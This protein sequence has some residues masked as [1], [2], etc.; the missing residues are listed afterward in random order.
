MPRPHSLL[1]CR[2]LACAAVFCTPLL[3]QS[4]HVPPRTISNEKD[5]SLRDAALME[6]LLLLAQGSRLA[7]LDLH[8]GQRIPDWEFEYGAPLVAVEYDPQQFL[9]VT[10]TENRLCVYNLLESLTPRI[11]NLPPGEKVLTDVKLLPGQPSVP[12]SARVALLSLDKLRTIQAVNGQLVQTSARSAP[13]DPAGQPALSA[14]LRLCVHASPGGALHALVCGNLAQYPARG[15]EGLASYAILDTGGNGPQVQPASWL[16]D[17][18]AAFG[19][20]AGGDP[21]CKSSAHQV[22]C[23][24][25]GGLEHLYVACGSESPGPGRARALLLHLSTGD[26]DQ[27][28]ALAQRLDFPAALPDHEVPCA[29]NLVADAARTK[30][31]VATS[32]MLHRFDLGSQAW[33]ASTYAEFSDAGERDLV[34]R[35]SGASP[36]CILSASNAGDDY[37]LHA[38]RIAGGALNELW[39]RPWISS[40]DG[41]VIVPE[42]HALYLPTFGGLLCYDASNLA[43]PFVA[44]DT[45]GGKRHYEP[46]GDNTEHVAFLEVDAAHGYVVSVRGAGGF[47]SWEV[48]AADKNPA[49][50]V[51]HVRNPPNSDP[52]QPPSVYANG[53]ETWTKAGQRWVLHD[54]TDR[55]TTPH[56]YWLQAWKYRAPDDFGSAPRGVSVTHPAIGAGLSV[57]CGAYEHFALVGGQG[58]LFVADLDPLLAGQ[59]PLVTDVVPLPSPSFSATGIECNGSHLYVGVRDTDGPNRL[60]TYVFDAA[61]GSV[62]GAQHE[63][64]SRLLGYRIEGRLRLC[65]ETKRLYAAGGFGELFEFDLVVPGAPSWLSTWK[66][67]DSGEGQDCRI[68]HAGSSPRVLFAENNEAFAILDP[69]DG[70]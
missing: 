23:I 20:P 70:L 10:A 30:L 14:M 56:T 11:W 49:P 27:P 55:S 4:P 67:S 32:N 61:H 45:P 44:A 21:A 41:A 58:L 51:A 37:E 46:S 38:V 40:S 3:A 5:G 34:C 52:T 42:W 35:E 59:A 9:L 12:T 65:P 43:R 28:P 17:P 19:C 57:L 47:E 26:L 2:L 1:P 18:V 69:E 7:A 8:T 6:P 33:E 39:R 36:A 54:V 53:I 29:W 48:N 25:S 63:V 62:G 60:L 66:G 15:L 24:S 16:Y 64:L 50:P 31:Y 13:L 22:Q 68:F